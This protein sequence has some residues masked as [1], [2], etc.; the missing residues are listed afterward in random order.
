MSLRLRLLA[1]ED[2]ARVLAWRNSPQVSAYMYSDHQISQD[3]HDR[4][5]TAALG[6]P[7]RRYWI[8]EAEDAPVGLANLARI[9]KAAQRCEWAY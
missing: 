5:L 7:D 6:A 4:W 8:I 2:S 1:P 3:E 9:D